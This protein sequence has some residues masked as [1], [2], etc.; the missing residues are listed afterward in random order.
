MT[1][2]N[3]IVLVTGAGSGIGEAI[4]I[5]FAKLSARLYLI[6]KNGD[7]LKKT[8]EV[9][10]KL[11]RTKV[12]TAVADLADDDLVE[13]VINNAKKE[14]GR[15]DVVVN[16]I[17]ICKRTTILDPN[18]IQVYDEVMKNNLR[19]IV[20]ITNCV[21]PI[22]I[23]SQGCLVNISSVSAVLTSKE[24]IVYC[25]S[26]AALNHFSK[27]VALE[28]APKGVR[29]NCILS[30]PVATNILI[31]AGSS[32]EDSDAA[33]KG[34]KEL[35]PLKQLVKADEVAEL[36]AFLTS[37]KAKGITGSIYSVDSGYGL[38]GCQDIRD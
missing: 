26:K 7:G 29:V 22:L 25:T 8:A 32:K 13:K 9:C 33:W 14:F 27:C 24:L 6:D 1:F 36:A 21:A 2:L 38:I 10:E 31:N 4:S 3:K 37:D 19:S 16:C 23:E 28:L 35:A 34:A 11:S 12:F 30:G 20:R 15:I 17:G 18:I 5:N